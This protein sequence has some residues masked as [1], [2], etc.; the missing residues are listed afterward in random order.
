MTRKTTLI[1]F[2]LFSILCSSTI[3]LAQEKFT[4]SGKI[5]DGS[6][7]EDLI[8]AIL[9]VKEIN[10]G[11]VSNEYGFYSITL[12]Q[13][14]YSIQV[15]YLGFANFEKTVELTSSQKLNVEMLAES[16]EL[17]EVVITSD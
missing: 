3:L 17:Q 15:S 6:N 9:T 1:F 5:K 11:V 10:S 16:S 8:G 14:T 2:I 13:G 4:L 7:G 12:P